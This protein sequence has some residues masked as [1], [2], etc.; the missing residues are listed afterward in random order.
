L[1]VSHFFESSMAHFDEEM[2]FLEDDI[3][4]GGLFSHMCGLKRGLFLCVIIEITILRSP[5]DFTCNH[6][7][8]F[9]GLL[10]KFKDKPAWLSSNK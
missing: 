6:I 5:C 10:V 1:S 4:L 7:L 2:H 9:L 3:T 8:L